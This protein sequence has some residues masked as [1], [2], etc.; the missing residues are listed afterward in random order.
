MEIVSVEQ[1]TVKVTLRIENISFGVCKPLKCLRFCGETPDTHKQ[2]SFLKH[3]WT[4]LW[5]NIPNVTWAGNDLF[6]G[7][8]V[9]PAE[10]QEGGD[11]GGFFFRA[12][13]G[14]EGLQWLTIL[15]QGYG[16]RAEFLWSQDFSRVVVWYMALFE[17]LISSLVLIR[18]AG[19]EGAGSLLPWATTS[20]PYQGQAASL[21]NTD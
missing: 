15:V 12:A 7:C 20:S 19:W 10:R 18:W 8:V 3:I 4:S 14:G 9:S 1:A 21:I 17:D 2:V 11:H 16:D 13:G 5:L 6:S